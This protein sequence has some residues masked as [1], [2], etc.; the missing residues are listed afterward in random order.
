MR[1]LPSKTKRIIQ[2]MWSGRA[3]GV[4]SGVTQLGR[5]A[6][7]DIEVTQGTITNISDA[8]AGKGRPLF[9]GAGTVMSGGIDVHSHPTG[10][11]RIGTSD[12][13]H[14]VTAKEYLAAGVTQ[15]VG[16]LGQETWRGAAE[17]LLLHV[18]ALQKY[19]MRAHMYAGGISEYAPSITESHA[20]DIALI[21]AVVGLKVSTES[22]RSHLSATVQQV[23]ETAQLVAQYGKPLRVHVH[24]G[25]TDDDLTQLRI[26]LTRIPQHI[27]VM[28][29]H[30]NWSRK[31][32]TEV[33]KH[34]REHTF[35][36]L[37]ACI[38]GQ[39]YP[40]VPVRNAAGH[41]FDL[42]VSATSVSVSSDSNGG[43]FSLPGA[44]GTFLRD[45]VAMLPRV[46]NDVR[47]AFDAQ[48][49]QRLFHGTPAIFLGGTPGD[50]AVGSPS[51]VVV[52]DN[53]GTV[54]FALTRYGQQYKHTEHE[55]RR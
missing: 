11:A 33:S 35:L 34:A 21:D 41:L 54:R 49:A 9:S 23:R 30:C 27:P 1:F 15:V 5:D 2:A 20:Q 51:D 44:R 12:S 39:R 38:D 7:C 25:S 10:G 3:N 24:V 50:I 45:D 13:V 4:I 55:E 42:G 48:T 8:G 47:E 28:L 32:L 6:P 40:G 16:C 29:T 36:D 31:H 18:R 52:R 37:T 19:G 26:F 53:A 46:W 14:F 17:V 43:V 22:M